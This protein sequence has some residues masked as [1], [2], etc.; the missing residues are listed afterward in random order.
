MSLEQ[1]SVFEIFRA[2]AARFGARPFLHIPAEATAAYAS[3]AVDYTYGAALTEVERL[4]PR[5]RGAGLGVGARVGLILENRAEFFFHWLA[6]NAIG[7]SVVP[8]NA[9]AQADEMAHICDDSGLVMIV[10]LPE[11]SDIARAIMAAAR[12]VK[13]IIPSDSLA[14]LENSGGPGNDEMPGRDTECALLYTSGSTGKPKGCMLSNDYFYTVG[15]WYRNIG[16]YCAIREGEDRLLTPLPLVHMN[17]LCT[18]TMVMIMTGGCIIQLD[19]FHPS[20]WLKT[21]RETGASIIHYLGVLPAILLQLPPRTDDRVHRVRFGFGAGVNPR[22]QA[23]FEARF[24]F[25]LIET[26]S[27]TEVGGAAA[28]I[29]SVDPRH[30]GASCF[31]KPPATMN[32]RLVDDEGCDVP[33]GE[34]GEFLVRRAGPDPRRG[35]F[36]GYWGKPEETELSW[37]GGWF[38]TGDLVR[39]GPDGSLHF[40]DR[41]KSIIRRSGENISSLEVE[42]VISQL[43]CVKAAGAA[44]VPDELRGDEV[45][46]AIVVADGFKGDMALAEEMTRMAGESLS[47]YKM[48]GYIAFVDALPLTASQKLQRGELR[49]I[50]RQLVEAG[51][52]HDLRHLK[53]KPKH[54]VEAR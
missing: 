34:S 47:Y 28:V 44:P 12:H 43:P 15:D 23:P 7:A 30:V 11:R 41:K 22:H 8:L 24:G 21:V 37:Q 49:I 2:T 45:F 25:P 31:G 54:K 20:T 16:G 46:V 38:H 6:L 5:Y 50:A 18:S 33:R 39:E 3:G 1:A 10:T 42:A 4:I 36:S 52:A 13:F 14:G 27:M 9:E 26:W 19:R 35:F 29:A 51:K 32:W 17:A 53:K 40:V 48:P